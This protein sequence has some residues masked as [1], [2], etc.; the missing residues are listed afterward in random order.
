MLNAKAKCTMQNAK[1][2][3]TMQNVKYITQKQ[4]FKKTSAENKFPKKFLPKKFPEEK[5]LIFFWLC[6]K[7]P[8]IAAEGCSPPQE[9]GKCN[10][11]RE[12]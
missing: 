8:T 3:S 1:F 11:W 6:P 9:L 2:K 5:K 7:G 10:E 4:K 12:G